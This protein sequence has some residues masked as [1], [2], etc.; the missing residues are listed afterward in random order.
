MNN[1]TPIDLETPALAALAAASKTPFL[2][3][4]KVTLEIGLDRLVLFSGFVLVAVVAY[5]VLKRL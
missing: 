5:E 2:T 3:A 4:L 1:Q